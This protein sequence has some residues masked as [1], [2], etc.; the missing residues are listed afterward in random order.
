MSKKSYQIRSNGNDEF[1]IKYTDDVVG[2]PDILL[3][4]FFSDRLKLF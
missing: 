2:W 3:N 1:Y 4:L